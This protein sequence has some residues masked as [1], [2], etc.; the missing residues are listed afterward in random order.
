MKLRRYR[1][2][3]KSHSELNVT[4]LVDVMLVLLV[5]FIV[6]TPM[7]H[8]NVCVNLPKVGAGVSQNSNVLPLTVSIQGDGTLWFQDQKIEP[9]VLVERLNV[10]SPDHQETIYIEADKTLVYEHL[11]QLMVCLS[12]EGFTKL[13]LV[14][15]ADSKSNSGKRR[16]I[17]GK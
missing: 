1:N 16:K 9:N 7:M 6:T 2:H 13:M 8:S 15:E 3:I 12:Q 5:I 11:V 10:L 14:T 17:R 4:P